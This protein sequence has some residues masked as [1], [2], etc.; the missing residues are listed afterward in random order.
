M[1]FFPSADRRTAVGAALLLAAGFADVASAPDLAGI[2][3][4]TLGRRP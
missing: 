2:E 4:I 3:R 1:S